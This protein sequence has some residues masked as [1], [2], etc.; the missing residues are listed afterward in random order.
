VPLARLCRPGQLIGVDMDRASLAA[1][2]AR[3]RSQAVSVHLVCGDIET[4]PVAD[5][6]FDTILDF[7]TCYHV[8]SPERAV[9]E[10]A[11]VLREGGLF[12]YE[13]LLN[14]LMAHPVLSVKRLLPWS[15]A[16]GLRPH[17]WVGLWASRVKKA[18]AAG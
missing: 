7:G 17:R 2:A 15:A 10:I 14:Q 3:I 18:A 8:A 9:L 1:A 12:V 11:R 13:T 4:L 16:P 5:G 6:S